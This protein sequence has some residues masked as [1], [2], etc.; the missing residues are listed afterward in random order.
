MSGEIELRAALVGQ[1]RGDAALNALVNRVHDGE[2]AKA[3]PPTV[4][5]GEAL[6]SDWGTKDVPGCE[7][8]IAVTIIDMAESAARIGAIMPLVEAGVRQVAATGTAEWVVASAGLIRSRLVGQAQGKCTA[9]L[10][11]RLRAL[12]RG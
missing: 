12:R 11:F 5:V 10:D 3:S 7:L 8:R 1:L 2:P 6:G 4:V 9:V